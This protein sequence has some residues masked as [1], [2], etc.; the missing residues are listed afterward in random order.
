MYM[1]QKFKDWIE[2]IKVQGSH[3]IILNKLKFYELHCTIG[4]NL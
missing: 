1:Y 3:M 2:Q 4:Q